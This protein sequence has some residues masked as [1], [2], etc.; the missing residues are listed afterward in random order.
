MCGLRENAD[1]IG[2]LCSVPVQPWAPT[3]KVQPWAPTS[4]EVCKGSV[5]RI[6][7]TQSELES[8][9]QGVD[10]IVYACVEHRHT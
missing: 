9:L 2:M 1:A 8:G 4:K 6:S 3:S 5:A 7:Q 10:P